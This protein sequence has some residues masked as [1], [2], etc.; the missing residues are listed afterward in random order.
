MAMR[1][2]TD[3][4]LLRLRLLQAVMAIALVFLGM[5]LWRI[6]VAHG[7]EHL[8][9]VEQQ[10]IRRVRLP[11]SRGAIY[12]RHGRPLVEN[13]PSYNVVVYLEELRRPGSWDNTVAYVLEVIDQVARE[14]GMAPEVSE[15]DIRNHIRRRRPMP[16]VVFRDID[17]RAMAR[18]AERT[19]GVPGIDLYTEP[20]RT[21]LHGELACHTLGYVGRA[22]APED[23][24][25]YDY[26]LPEMEGRLGVE[27]VYDE[28]LR[29]MAGGYLMRVDVSLFRYDDP[30]LESYRVE[31]RMGQD[32]YLAL[33]LRI[34]RAA[35]QV[36]EGET[37]AV[38]VLDPSNGDVLAIASTPGFNN[39]LFVPRMLTSDWRELN[40]DPRHP[41]VNRATAGT[42]APGSIFKPVVALAG[43][44]G[45]YITSAQRYDCPGRF[46]LG[47]T[48]FHC[49]HRPG[50]GSLD[51]V[52]SLQFSCNVYY[53][54]LGLHIGHEPIV[55]MARELGL[56][57]LTGIEMDHERTGL[58]PDDAWKR[59]IQRDAWRDGDTCNLSIGQGALL[60]TP[61]QMAVYC[62]AIANGGQVFEPRLA[63]GSG[64]TGTAEY[65]AFPI[66]RR[67][68]VEWNPGDISAVREGMRRVVMSSRGTGRAARAGEVEIAGKTGTAQYGPRGETRNHAWMIAYAPFDAPRY[69]VA[70]L[71]EDGVSGGTTAAPRMGLLFREL[72]AEA[73]EGG[74]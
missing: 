22:E 10:S 50:H 1:T 24:E 47:N 7:Q 72:F 45:R 3:G 59:R 67:N 32:L 31:P 8:A 15:Q 23:Q 52:D 40:E 5:R 26:Y 74:E 53:Y 21:Y 6:Q 43:M 4:E 49:W 14:I 34:Q 42:Y 46:N 17:E 69:A 35:E 44:G 36:M 28:W 56:G 16:L 2:A 65:Q 19:T 48:T 66:R 39:N 68:R 71:I 73:G 63:L 25:T 70:M 58:V 27:R 57:R 55:A 18:W 64:R 62:A 54:R 37:G 38:V 60:V 41:Q 51:L 11:G 20:V 9:S 33:D 30:G 61:L 29:G 13:R 12:D